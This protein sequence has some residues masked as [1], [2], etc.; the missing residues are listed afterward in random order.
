M[1]VSTQNNS[2][3]H[4]Q[5]SPAL[6]LGVL[7]VVYG[8][9]GTSPLYALRASLL[10][11]AA[12]GL[13]DWE[14][15]GVLSLIFWSLILVVTVKYVLLVLRADNRG[16]G[17]IL[18][19]MALAMRVARG[20]RGRAAVMMIGIAG[21]SL[22]FG[23][24]IITPAI[25]VLSAVEGLKIISPAFTQ[26][27]IPISLGV[28]LAL[29][30]VQYKGTHTIGRIFGPVTALWFLSLGVLGLIEIVVQPHVLLAL[31]PHYAIAF[32]LEYHLAAFIALGSVVL[33][34]TGAEA[35]YADMGHF[36]ARPI[37]LVWLWA[38]L[39]A[40]TLNYFGQGAL[41]LS[42]RTALENPFYLLA[43]EWFRL[44][45]VILA[46]CATIIA[47]QAMISGAFSI[48]RQC[49][50]LGYLPRMVV[51]HTSETEEGQIYMPQINLLL[52]AGVI[53]L[54]LSFHDSDS[55]AAAYGI[56]V[57]GTFLCT[58]CLAGLV[59]RRQFG[60]SRLGVAL[61]VVP[62]LLLDAGFFISNVLKVPDGGWVPLLLGAGM[63]ALM[64]TWRRGRELL[65]ARFRQD[66]LPLKSFL[67]RLPQ[68]RT[69]R[70]PGIAVFMTGQAD[71]VPAALLHNLKHNKV[72]HERVLF[73][74]VENEDVPQAQQRREVSELA[75][76]IH[77]V[78][79]RYGFQESP[80]IPRELEALRE[81]GVE[82]ESMQASYFLG[83]ETLVAAAVP[84][85][86][87]WRQWLFS[88][89]S[90]NSMPATEFFRIPSDRVVELGVRVAI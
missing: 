85:M 79:L 59:F 29:F 49:V 17:G 64:L 32:C 5:L 40:L 83:R 38:V 54:V 62:M 10:H 25:S 36:G 50:Q 58:T 73:V 6:L 39:P 56:A 12:D 37:R 53:V 4:R 69:I 61:V 22:F 63:F 26:A 2:P 48:A 1:A 57:T 84:K 44:P 60:W 21:A 30:L 70:V 15:L 24:G 76:G 81:Y 55:L 82:F 75:P 77:R 90:R 27:V 28:L 33:A 3:A 14:I 71:Y 35:L 45:L 51:T 8:D 42:D 19:L 34:V 89:L 74:T 23:D 87:A 86:P 47:S 66:S 46:T 31:S 78:I 52:L 13:E 9:I 41:L 43:P 20:E 16:E 11:F 7:G 65:F 67:A 18:A 88:V 72:L 80:N 68:S